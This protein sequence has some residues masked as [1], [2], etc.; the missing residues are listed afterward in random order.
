MTMRRIIS[1]LGVAVLALAVSGPALAGNHSSGGHVMKV[2]TTKSDRG[3]D[4]RVIRFEKGHERF[5][6]RRWNA[7]Y[8]C[9]VYW[10]PEE[11]CYCYWCEP[12]NCYYPV[13]FCPY[14][15]YSF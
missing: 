3:R 10:C 12:D 7:D 9:Y 14:G 13:F 6:R 1:S 11:E 4:H 5:T 15:R 8:G 2:Y